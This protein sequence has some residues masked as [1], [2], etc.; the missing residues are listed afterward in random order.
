MYVTGRK[1]WYFVSYDPRFIK[2]EK[3]L[4]V[5]RIERNEIDIKK[6]ENRLTEAIRRKKE[7]LK[8]FE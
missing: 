2:L 3:R 5:L 1:Y 4:F 6:L 8:A 7:R